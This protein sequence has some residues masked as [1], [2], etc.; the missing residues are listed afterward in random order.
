M[1]FKEKVWNALKEIPAIKRVLDM[2]DRIEAIEKRLDTIPSIVC[3]H[4]GSSDIE[5]SGTSNPR[6]SAG[7]NHG[8]LNF[9]Y[10]CKKCNETTCYLGK[11]PLMN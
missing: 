10:K 1:D 2:P 3:E 6:A 4:C 7:V 5:P 9:H 11:N 8:L